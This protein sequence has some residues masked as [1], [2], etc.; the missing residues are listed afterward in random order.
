[1]A[2][3]ASCVAVHRNL[4][5]VHD[6][7]PRTLIVIRIEDAENLE[8]HDLK[9]ALPGWHVGWSSDNEVRCVPPAVA[10]RGQS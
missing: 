8:L 1:V 4:L 5:D 6:R 3:L 10:P 7:S 9:L 2:Y